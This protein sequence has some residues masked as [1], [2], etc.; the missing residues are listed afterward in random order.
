MSVLLNSMNLSL[1]QTIGLIPAKKWNRFKKWGPWKKCYFPNP[2]RHFGLG[3]S[4]F[5]SMAANSFGVLATMDNAWTEAESSSL[6]TELTAL[7]W[8]QKL[9]GIL[10]L[11][12]KCHLKLLPCRKA[13]C[14]VSCVQSLMYF[15]LKEYSHFS[16]R[17]VFLFKRIV[18]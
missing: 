15:C 4:S 5:C 10:I 6:R 9:A 13:G 11:D 17:F 14:S 8:F 16:R 7:K 12:K 1:Q 2:P 18:R 3:S